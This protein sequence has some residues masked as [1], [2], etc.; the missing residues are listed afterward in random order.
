MS[1]TFEFL[2]GLP[3]GGAGVGT[4][5]LNE[6]CCAGVLHTALSG[7]PAGD[8]SGRVSGDALMCTTFAAYELIHNLKPTANIVQWHVISVRHRDI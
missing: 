2:L 4:T 7:A 5:S 3:Y 6:G 1:F 8:Y